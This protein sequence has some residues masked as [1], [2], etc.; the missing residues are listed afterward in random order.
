MIWFY[1]LE[2]QWTFLCTGALF[3]NYIQ[4]KLPIVEIMQTNNI[5]NE[6]NATNNAK[7]YIYGK[8]GSTHYPYNNWY[9]FLRKVLCR[10]HEDD[11]LVFN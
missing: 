8:R 3:S 4:K 6:T 5:N 11:Q 10:C 9:Y 2:Q 1:D 7:N